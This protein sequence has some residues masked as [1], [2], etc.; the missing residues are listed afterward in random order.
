[1][2]SALSHNSSSALRVCLINNIYPPFHRGGAEQVVVKTVEG[3]RAA[4]HEVIL[5]TASP[6]GDT[7]EKQ[8]GLTIYRF[9][10]P[11]IYFYTKAHEHHAAMR[12]LW[13]LIN[14][15]HWPVA[16]RVKR[17]VQQEQ[18]DIVHTHNLMGLSFL[19]PR[20]IASLQIPHVHT[21]HD[22]QLVEP[23]G[24]ILK[25]KEHEWRYRGFPSKLYTAVV[26]WLFGSPHVVISPSKF[27]LKFYQERGF[28][29]HSKGTVVR[30]PLTFTWHSSHEQRRDSTVMHFLYV[31]QIES[32]KG[33]TV[34]VDAFLQLK[35][36]HIV[37]HIVGSG[38]LLS[39]ITKQTASDPRVVMHGRVERDELARLFST[40][41]MTIVPSRC[42]EN[43]P[44]VIFESFS[45][46]VPVLASNVEGIAELIDEEKNGM[47]FQPGDVA[48][49]Q[50]KISWCIQHRQEVA[51]MGQQTQA[52]LRDITKQ[53][54][55]SELIARYRECI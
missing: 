11:N 27:L 34:L 23:S 41:D 8:P 39:S 10:P 21:V 52:F 43:S 48:S 19:I 17:I 29:P 47:T 6:E 45:F 7:V 42:Y 12:M 1:M 53:E 31:G 49:L 25:E 46:G 14:L 18:P 50:E 38:S 2:E 20:I 51:T 4:G 40:I 32:H 35:E 16:Q 5:I 13:H 28:F 30:N 37:L 33:I 55:I 26:R 36:H 54:Y 24:I 44:T 15:F 22:V 3:L 9:T